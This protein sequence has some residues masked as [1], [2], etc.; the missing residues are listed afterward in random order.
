MSLTLSMLQ[1]REAL[2]EVVAATLNAHLTDGSS[3]NVVQ[4]FRK[5]VEETEG[6]LDR[7]EHMGDPIRFARISFIGT[8]N[9]Q[10]PLDFN[11]AGGVAQATH[12]FIVLVWL[13]YDDDEDEAVASQT[14]WDALIEGRDTVRGLL[15]TLRDAG[16]LSSNDEV[17]YLGTPFDVIAPDEPLYLGDETFAH[18]L[19]FFINIK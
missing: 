9:E 11:V 1:K 13:E 14:L 16:G 8:A 4:R 19:Q 10:D 15:P 2:A 12:T 5:A 3:F 18:Y 6:P 17:A 7:K